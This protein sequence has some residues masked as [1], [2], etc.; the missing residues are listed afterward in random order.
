MYETS[1]ERFK[2]DVAELTDV[3]DKVEKIRGVSFEWNDKA[4]SVGVKASQ[5]QIGVVAQ[6]VESVFPEL[7]ASSADGYKSVDY[8]KLTA[9]LVEAVKDLK[10]QN[11]SLRKR[12]EALET[13]VE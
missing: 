10:A 2:T 1:D 7:V 3:L 5:K 8:T 9:V 6:E 11:E 13:A 4:K 12:L